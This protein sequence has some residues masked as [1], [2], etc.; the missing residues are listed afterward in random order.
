MV[1]KYERGPI[2]N[3][4]K[5]STGFTAGLILGGLALDQLQHFNPAVGAVGSFV[6]SGVVGAWTGVYDYTKN[7]WAG[8][9]DEQTAY[10]L[11]VFGSNIMHFVTFWTQC[12]IHTVFDF[13]PTNPLWSWTQ[14]WRIQNPDEPT[15]R[16]KLFKTAMGTLT[17]TAPRQ[18]R[19]L[20]LRPLARAR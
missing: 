8:G 1:R 17:R 2:K 4:L 6:R 9:D 18:L 20:T 14:A 7:N 5:S 19:P 16:M 3:L 13:W 11:M 15:N 10:L 12:L